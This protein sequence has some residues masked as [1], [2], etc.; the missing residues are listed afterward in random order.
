[1]SRVMV[2]ST[3]GQ[4]RWQLIQGHKLS[5]WLRDSEKKNTTVFGCF[6]Y[7]MLGTWLGLV[8][9]KK[10]EINQKITSSG[11]WYC[12]WTKSCTTKD[13]GCPIIYRV[14][15]I[16]GGAGFC[17]STVGGHFSISSVEI[18]GFWWIQTLISRFKNFF[19]RKNQTFSPPS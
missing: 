14:L 8:L 16:P 4:L 15:T 12:W 13:D 7:E 9:K 2:A 10:V 17:P 5:P 19:P 6:W 3:C 1:M 11:K 18:H